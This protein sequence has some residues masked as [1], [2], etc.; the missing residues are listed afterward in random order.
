MALIGYIDNINY[1]TPARY[2]WGG[3]NGT[4]EK[5][6]NFGRII[7]IIDLKIELFAFLMENIALNRKT[8]DGL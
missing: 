3:F 1:K 8:K 5:Y 4:R 7:F 6:I 2:C